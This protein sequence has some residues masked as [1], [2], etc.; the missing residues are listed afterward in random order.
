MV[1]T[2]RKAVWQFLKLTIELP[3]EVY[4]QA[5]QLFSV[6]PKD[7]RI[8]AHIKLVHKWHVMSSA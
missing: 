2:L 4:G 3:Y 6:Y 8:Y 5:I 7:M 1:Q